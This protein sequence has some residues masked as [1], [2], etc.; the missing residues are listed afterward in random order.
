MHRLPN[1]VAPR[2]RAGALST[3]EDAGNASRAGQTI[4]RLPQLEAT[5]MR[6]IQE[7][8]HDVAAREWRR[9]IVGVVACEEWAGAG[10]CVGE[11]NAANLHA[12]SPSCD[13]D[14]CL[15]LRLFGPPAWCI[16]PA[17]AFIDLALLG[18]LS[19]ASA[20]PACLRVWGCL[21]QRV[22]PATHADAG[23]L[24]AANICCAGARRAR[25][26]L[27]CVPASASLRRG[28]HV[29]SHGARSDG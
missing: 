9:H 29:P 3:A 20:A 25:Q 10:T 5:A 11:R 24:S 18:R 8:A 6:G 22:V 16:Q 21:G 1:C 27:A 19:T 17:S 28:Y 26:M 12:A 14:Y 7:A 2:R 13:G 15:E 23:A 4:A